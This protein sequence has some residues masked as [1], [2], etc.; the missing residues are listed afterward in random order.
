MT[1][2]A[3][4]F[5]ALTKNYGTYGGWAVW[6]YTNDRL[7]ESSTE[8]IYS[9]IELLNSRHVIIGLN[10]S[11]PLERN[12]V[13]FRGGMHDRK[14]KYAFNDTKVRGSYM[15]DLL[16]VCTKTSNELLNH[17][18]SH[19][20]VLKE[21]VDKFIKEMRDVKVSA[22]TCFIILGTEMGLLGSLYRN[23]FQGH[24]PTNQ[25][26]YYRLHSSRGTDR[27]WVEGIWE[28]LKISANYDE[29]R[30]RYS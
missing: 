11:K 29:I 20:N 7:S 27:A 4:E 25:V 14:L 3:D 15:T 2:S 23:H 13:N 28:K 18:I 9:N 1:F 30:K 16:K 19:P 10:I 5:E 6:H 26:I 22:D 21:N 12:W 8:P 24:F 17:L